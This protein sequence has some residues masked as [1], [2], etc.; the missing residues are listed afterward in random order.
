MSVLSRLLMKQGVLASPW[1][2]RVLAVLP[3][4]LLLWLGVLWALGEG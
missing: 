4:C 1:W 2:Q 3:I